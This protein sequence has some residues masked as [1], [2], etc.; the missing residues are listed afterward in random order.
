MFSLAEDVVMKGSLRGGSSSGRGTR[1]RSRSGSD[2][3]SKSRKTSLQFR[4]LG[5]AFRHNPLVTVYF[6]LRELAFRLTYEDDR[7]RLNNYKHLSMVLNTY[8]RNPRIYMTEK[9]DMTRLFYD[10]CGIEAHLLEADQ[11]RAVFKGSAPILRELCASIVK[12][13]YG[14]LNHRI[15]LDVSKAYV[16]NRLRNYIPFTSESDT[17]RWISMEAIDTIKANMESMSMIPNLIRLLEEAREG[18]AGGP[19]AAPMSVERSVATLSPKRES[20]RARQ[21]SGIRSRSKS[22][23]KS[24]LESKKRPFTQIRGA[25]PSSYARYSTRKIGASKRPLS[26]LGTI[27]KSGAIT[28]QHVV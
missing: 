6:F 12:N 15:N 21:E 17:K 27:K 18:A 22:T 1:K 26:T 7:D 24:R 4:S 2:S 5:G 14:I 16:R 11:Q 23:K 9:G 13:Y 28:R 3:G 10:A 8:I 19:A 25:K 20:K